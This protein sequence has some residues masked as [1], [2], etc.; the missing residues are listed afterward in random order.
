MMMPTPPPPPWRA[1]LPI[2][3]GTLALV[4]LVGGLGYWSVTARLAGAVISTGRVDVETKRQVIQ[5]PDGGVVGA[6]AVRNG[7][8]VEAGE[9]LVQLDATLFESERS[10]I[11]GQLNDI[12][13]RKARLIAERDD[14]EV[15]EF[16]DWLT[17]SGAADVK[18]VMEG[19]QRLFEARSVSVEREAE[20]LVER[21][22]QY[23]HEID[24]I[25]S[26]LEAMK[27]R[28]VLVADELRD[29]TSLLERGLT[30]ASRVSGLRH[31]EAR[32]L[33]E[34]GEFNASLAQLR[35]SVAEVNIE[36]I[37]LKTTRR[38]EAI[39]ELRDLEFREIELTER[40]LG[41]EERLSRLS[42]RAPVGG[43][44]YG[45][46]VFALQSVVQAGAPMMYVVPQDQP[47]VIEARVDPINVDQ[48]FRG[49]PAG[50][51]FTA[52]ESRT[53]PELR[54]SVVDLSADAFMDEATGQTYYLVEV[55]PAEG[56]LEKLGENKLI[57]GMPVEV[58][59]KTNERTPLEY[60]TKPL[61]DYFTRSMRG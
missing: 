26:Q 29:Q 34:I 40:M 43:V 3:V 28:Q 42:V 47:M 6:I 1:R 35:G 53:T 4:I 54:G 41:L 56:E 18:N 7:D 31:E 14:A 33:G 23:E 49:Q 16:P 15:V 5:H 39:T 30:Q 55:L 38:E 48:V 27:V 57:P 13:A 24:G 32:M 58:F 9:L 22:K 36:L 25:S 11:R 20:Q 21:R 60:L 45:S 17:S 50:L 37:K 44:I 12:G 59:I 61:T 46:E 52:F 19:Q 51:R 10:I 8:V 2:F